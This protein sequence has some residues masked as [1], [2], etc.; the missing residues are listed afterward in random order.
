MRNSAPRLLVPLK[1]ALAVTGG[2]LVLSTSGCAAA[3]AG[4]FLV[5]AER[6][7]HSALEQGAEDRA[8]YEA[9]LAG[10]YLEKAKE[11]DGYS[12]FGV[13]EKLCKRSMEMSAKALTRSEDLTNGQNGE[14]F[15]PEERE[16]EPE[17]PAEPAPDLDIDLD[18]P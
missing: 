2:M 18:D 16:K 15:V 1:L 17:K 9:T 7:Y 10:A 11:E 5:N 3:R 6:K 14:K 12:D 8:P 4:Y 13:T